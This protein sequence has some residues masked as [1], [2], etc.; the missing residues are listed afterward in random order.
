MGKGHQ[1]KVR[2]GKVPEREISENPHEESCPSQKSSTLQCAMKKRQDTE[3]PYRCG[4]EAANWKG[5]CVKLASC[6]ETGRSY[7]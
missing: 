1:E 2:N 7:R 5:G 4:Q 3:V 6:S